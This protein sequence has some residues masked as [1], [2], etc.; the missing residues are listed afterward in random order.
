MI[1][2]R[3]RPPV[4]TR[5]KILLVVCSGTGFTQDALDFFTKQYLTER[6]DYLLMAVPGALH[7]LATAKRKFAVHRRAIED[8][9]SFL[10]HQ[11]PLERVV[12]FDH[13]TCK[14]FAKLAL[15]DM[16]VAE[17]A[18]AE[19]TKEAVRSLHEIF[20]KQIPVDVWC[21]SSENGRISFER[22]IT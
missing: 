2:K 17:S 7:T 9:I 11:Q 18:Q 21:G 1:R 8:W 4:V 19:T 22:V 10:A 13:T 12:V 15:H 16:I 6:P 14:W 3:K 5:E 20:H